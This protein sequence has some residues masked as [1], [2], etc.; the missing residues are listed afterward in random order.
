M[1]WGLRLHDQP[2]KPCPSATM[3]QAYNGSGTV[4]PS[5]LRRPCSADPAEHSVTQRRM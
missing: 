1:C 5:M 4:K 2:S 3:L